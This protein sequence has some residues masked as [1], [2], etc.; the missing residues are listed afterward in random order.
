ML[1]N[2]Q[3]EYINVNK[4]VLK[5]IKSYKIIKNIICFT[6]THVRN[7]SVKFIDNFLLEWK[8]IHK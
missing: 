1:G 2:I 8:D 7:T 6:K 5:E 3:P 4:L